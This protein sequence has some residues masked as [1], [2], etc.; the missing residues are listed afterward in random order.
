MGCPVPDWESDGIPGNNSRHKVWEIVHIWAAL[1]QQA[2]LL[3]EM[4]CGLLLQVANDLRCTNKGISITGVLI[5]SG[6]SFLAWM[7][8]SANIELFKACLVTQYPRY[9]I[10]K[11]ARGN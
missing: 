5:H 2:T 3:N 6:V 10:S 8:H 1:N 9:V 4:V 11:I 7:K